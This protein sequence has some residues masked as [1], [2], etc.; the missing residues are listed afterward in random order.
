[1][2]SRDYSSIENHF[3]VY[4]YTSLE[5]ELLGVFCSKLLSFENY[6]GSQ[7][8]LNLLKMTAFSLNCNPNPFVKSKPIS[9][10]NN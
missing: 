1:M 9:D 5:V 4:K 10:F 3:P 2:I 6:L 7:E 8:L